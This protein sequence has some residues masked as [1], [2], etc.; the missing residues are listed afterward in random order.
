MA[1]FNHIPQISLFTLD[2]GLLCKLSSTVTLVCTRANFTPNVTTFHKFSSPQVELDEGLLR[3]LSFTA[4]GEL[5][6]MAAMFGG[7]VGQEVGE[8]RAFGG[9]PNF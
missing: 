9:C 6:P 2:E 1:P 7:V 5:N 3:K 4:R 8:I